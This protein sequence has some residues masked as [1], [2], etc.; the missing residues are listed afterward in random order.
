MCTGIAAD[1]VVLPLTASNICETYRIAHRERRKASR[2]GDKLPSLA[3]FIA[4]VRL[5]IGTDVLVRMRLLE[6]L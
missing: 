2:G 4:D 1:R 3:N 6:S 5:A